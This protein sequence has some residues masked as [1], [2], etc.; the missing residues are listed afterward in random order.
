MRSLSDLLDRHSDE[1]FEE[2]K[3][4]FRKAFEAN[5]KTEAQFDALIR[6]CAIPCDMR[7]AEP[8]HHTPRLEPQPRRPHPFF[9]TT[10]AVAVVA[11]AFST[12]YLLFASAL[13]ESD[14]GA[15]VTEV[16]ARG[17][18]KI[19]A[20]RPAALTDATEQEEP[21]DKLADAVVPSIA[22]SA[23]TDA[24]K[25]G[26]VAGDAANGPA[27]SLPRPEVAAV[28]ADTGVAIDRPDV[29]T[30]TDELETSARVEPPGQNQNQDVAGALSMIATVQPPAPTGTT[31][32]E[33]PPGK[34]AGVVVPSIAT[35][36][37]IATDAAGAAGNAGDRRDTKSDPSGGREVVP[38]DQ[39]RIP[40]PRAR[41]VNLS[42]REGAKS[43]PPDAAVSDWAYREMTR[44]TQ[45]P[46]M[47]AQGE[48]VV[49]SAQAVTCQ[50]S[51]PAGDGHW[52]WRLI[53][54]RKCWYKGAAGINK[55]LLHW[56]PLEPV[57]QL[58]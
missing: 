7:E 11:L 44:G 1:D 56:P 23:A 58:Q 30:G 26:D 43:P 46:N 57:P 49:T 27:P 9:L 18:P 17:S 37:S 54:G 2:L 40:I 36:P 42:L 51:G 29:K 45:T 55:S 52:A 32:Q 22:P 38:P 47:S 39:H 53:D 48:P 13:T 14:A 15:K 41:P 21:P 20:M 33:E 12:A 28:T 34:L 6:A 5:R 25:S 3:E 8:R 31:E 24:A 16:T 4:A 10:A 35:A 19:V 50:T